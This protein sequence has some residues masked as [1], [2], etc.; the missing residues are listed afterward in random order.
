MTDRIYWPLRCGGSRIDT[1]DM[2][3]EED[4]V[5]P[6]ESLHQGRDVTVP[7]PFVSMIAGKPTYEHYER[8]SEDD[9]YRAKFWR[10]MLFIYA[11]GAIGSAVGIVVLAVLRNA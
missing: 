11:I 5:Y 9:P 3:M 8:T 4:I 6:A 2:A 1:K 10:R 7:I